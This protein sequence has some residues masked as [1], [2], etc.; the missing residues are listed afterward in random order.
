MNRIIYRTLGGLLLL[1]LVPVRAFAHTD[2]HVDLGLFGPEPYYVEPPPVYY[3]PPVRYYS[4][5]PPVYYGP[6]VIYRHRDWDDREG[7]WEH[8]E[9]REHRHHDEGD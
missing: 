7:R 6:R 4:P 8:R 9:Y 2:V 1:A 3:E 5:P